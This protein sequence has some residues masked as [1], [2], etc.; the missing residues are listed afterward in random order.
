[1]LYNSQISYI[2]YYC[3]YNNDKKMVEVIEAN[4]F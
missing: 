1:M 3:S 2:G 4:D